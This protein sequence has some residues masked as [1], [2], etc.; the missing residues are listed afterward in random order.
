[1]C[2]KIGNNE[3]LTKESLPLD[4]ARH[5]FLIDLINLQYSFC[6]KVGCSE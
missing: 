1:M 5:S 3:V 2:L 6:S 4:Y